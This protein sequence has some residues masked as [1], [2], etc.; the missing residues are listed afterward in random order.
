[1]N[2]IDVERGHGRAGQNTGGLP[3]TMNSTSCVANNL[4]MS[5][6]RALFIQLPDLEGRFDKLLNTKES[7]FRRESEHLSDLC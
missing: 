2:N 1:M 4:R 5:T 7:L 3:T 6:N